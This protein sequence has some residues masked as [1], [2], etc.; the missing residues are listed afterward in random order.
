[1]MIR[2]DATSNYQFQYVMRLIVIPNLSEPYCKIAQGSDIAHSHMQ[3]Q[4]TRCM[5]EYKRGYSPDEGM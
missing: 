4:D 3:T 5:G 1:M 2:I